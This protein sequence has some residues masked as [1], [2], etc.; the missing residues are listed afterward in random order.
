[1]PMLAKIPKSFIT[2]DCVKSK[3]KKEIAVVE[4]LSIT[5]LVTTL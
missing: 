1:M 3:Q 4:L 2:S 5:G